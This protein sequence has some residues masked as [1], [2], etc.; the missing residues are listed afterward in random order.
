M[1]L[2]W[3]LEHGFVWTAMLVGM[4]VGVPIAHRLTAAVEFLPSNSGF[5]LL[6]GAILG[7]CIGFAIL[8]SSFLCYFMAAKLGWIDRR[9]GSSGFW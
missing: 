5:V 7:V 4:L 3:W 6:A 8:F 9:D 2:R 1:P